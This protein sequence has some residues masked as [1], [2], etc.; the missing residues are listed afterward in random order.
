LLSWYTFIA[1]TQMKIVKMIVNKE[2]LFF[3]L[4]VLTVSRHQYVPPA[5][6][7]TQA[8]HLLP[9]MSHSKAQRLEHWLSHC[10][11]GRLL[12][13]SVFS[14]DSTTAQI[15]KQFMYL[16]METSPLLTRG[17]N[18][19]SGTESWLTNLKMFTA[20]D[21]EHSTKERSFIACMVNMHHSF[22]FIAPTPTQI[23]NPKS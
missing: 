12:S 1:L 3:A 19:M 2:S 8:V 15:S 16:D 10:R 6:R 17:T 5:R 21:S 22:G 7:Y 9:T 11:Y 14:P 18:T 20:R 4:P 13:K 23:L